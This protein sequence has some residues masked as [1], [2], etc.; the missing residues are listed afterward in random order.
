MET[1]LVLTRVPL[2]ITLKL[3]ECDLRWLQNGIKKHNCKAVSV[4]LLFGLAVY[5]C[6]THRTWVCLADGLLR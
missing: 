1:L 2:P 5:L 3:H 6:W 4:A